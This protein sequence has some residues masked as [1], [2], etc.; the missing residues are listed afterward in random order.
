M[1]KN[2]SLKHEY[3]RL[4]NQIK[5]AITDFNS[6]SWDNFLESLG[7]GVVSSRPFWNRINAARSSGD[8]KRLPP[9][10]V[11]GTKVVDDDGKANLFADLLESTFKGPDPTLFDQKH[12][13]DTEKKVASFLSSSVS[14]DFPLVTVEE[15]KKLIAKCSKSSAPG[16]TKIHNMMLRNLPDKFLVLLVRL[17]N[18][19]LFENQLPEVWKSAKISMIPKTGVRSNDPANFRPIS[20]TCCLGKLCERVV[21]SRLYYFLESNN[22][23][24]GNQS[25]FRRFRRTTDNLVFLTQKCQQALRK[26]SKVCC[27]FFDIRKAFDNV[28]HCGLL[29]KLIDLKCPD[30]LTRWVAAFLN[31]RSFVVQVGNARSAPRPILV[32]V[33]QGAVLSPLLFNVFINDISL[34]TT[35]RNTP[36][37]STMFAD[38][39][40]TYFVFKKDGHLES[41]VNRYLD[42][43]KDWLKLNRL[44]MNVK[45]SVYAI[46]S[47]SPST[48]N[49]RFILCGETISRDSSPKF[50]GV[51]FDERLSFKNQVES[52]QQKCANRLNI[53]R[54]IS[55]RSWK[56]S[57]KTRL[58][59]YKALIGSV[60]DYSCFIFPLLND[61]L[62]KA[63]QA[64]QNKAVRAIFKK[65]FDCSTSELCE[66]S[67][68]RLVRDRTAELTLKYLKQ[69]K[70]NP[71]IKKLVDEYDS[72]YLSFTNSNV[73][74]KTLLCHFR[75]SMN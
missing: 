66:I 64:I 70:Y 24:V 49:Y 48:K 1:V 12:R 26:G 35:F 27:F 10:V 57:T 71:M 42:K 16:L 32:G 17:F 47:R 15:V 36:S 18:L 13:V 22:K 44:Q 52:I 23:L 46:F 61:Q 63:L 59:I 50:L 40:A 11:D 56:L 8:S 43:L 68:L 38:D 3:N 2:Q 39:L 37:Y 14:D 65:P 60:I 21:H 30:Y 28:W 55:H 5:S 74:C 54:I 6:K 45:K 20:V 62:A 7:T 69:A 33:P 41:V 75:D 58:S 67:G 31:G 73:A 29:G 72:Q 4:T 51:V 19:S 53:I 25:G 9:L 34:G